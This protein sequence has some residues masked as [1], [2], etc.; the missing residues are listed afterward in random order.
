MRRVLPLEV[1]QGYMAA[2]TPETT[3]EMTREMMAACWGQPQAW[4]HVVVARGVRYRARAIA[5]RGRAPHRVWTEARVVLDQAGAAEQAKQA[6]YVR[7]GKWQPSHMG[8]AAGRTRALPLEV[9]VP[10]MW[11]QERR[12]CGQHVGA[13]VVGGQS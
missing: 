8:G 3:P 10:D 7:L 2:I 12:W 9:V 6:T 1:P 11:Q 5:L 13:K 4:G